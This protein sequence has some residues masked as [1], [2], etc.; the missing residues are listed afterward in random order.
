MQTILD[1]FHEHAAD[2]VVSVGA[3]VPA[4]AQPSLW[5][6]AGATAAALGVLGILAGRLRARRRIAAL[7]GQPL[8][9]DMIASMGRHKLAMVVIGALFFGGFGGWAATFELASAAVAPGVVSPEGS[10]RPVQHLEGGIVRAVLVREGE[11]V[12]AGAPLIVLEDVQARAQVD[13]LLDQRT[14]LEIRLQRLRAERESAERFQSSIDAADKPEL[15]EVL[16]QEREQFRSRR[17]SLE[18]QVA[19]QRSRIAQVTEE[20]AGL[21]RQA[22][23]LERQSLLVEEELAGAR[24]LLEKGHERRPRVLAL[25]R[26]LSEIT[27]DRAAALARIARAR[28]NAAEAEGQIAAIRYA[29]AEGVE[30]ETAQARTQLVQIA[31]QLSAHND[32]LLRRTV[33]APETGVVIG[34]RVTSSLAVVRP[35]DVIAEIVPDEAPLLIDAQVQP[36]D[37]DDVREGL[38]AQ[39]HLSAFKQRFLPRVTGTVRYVS[40]DRHVD[41]RSGMP[42][43]IARVEIPAD[44]LE[45]LGPGI[46]IIAGMPAEVMI[47]TG[48]QTMLDYLLGPLMQAL[49]RSFREA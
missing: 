42:Y 41:E 24:T 36:V 47:V 33:H 18:G 15:H 4:L 38:D 2:L 3:I 22:A 7:R 10:R 19:I 20:I 25:E 26:Q 44:A 46:E 32:V 45:S 6:I 49:N 9:D 43:F 31:N 35:G 13:L 21:E 17:A 5:Q 29:F 1:L 27:A 30:Q 14:M 11:R 23:E 37:I 40:A 16:A 28:E 39:V 48:R 8:A 12:R 34:L